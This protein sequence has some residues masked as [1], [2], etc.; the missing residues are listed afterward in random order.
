R[1]FSGSSTLFTLAKH[2]LL[3]SRSGQ[4]QPATA[5]NPSVRNRACACRALRSLASSAASARYPRL[6]QPEAVCLDLFQ[7]DDPASTPRPAIAENIGGL[8]QMAFFGAS[9]A[10]W[11]FFGYLAG[12]GSRRAQHEAK[13][14]G[15]FCPIQRESTGTEL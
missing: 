2:R 9:E 13:G 8:A 14:T 4:P 12:I 7:A 1:V 15:A 3:C 6:V 10:R 5:Q 11:L